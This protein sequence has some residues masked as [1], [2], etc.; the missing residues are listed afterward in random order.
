MKKKFLAMTM[1][2]LIVVCALSGIVGARDYRYFD[3]HL[4]YYG[5]VQETKGFDVLFQKMDTQN[6]KKAVVFGIHS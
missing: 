4:H 1:T 2:V 5:F 3:M 6:V